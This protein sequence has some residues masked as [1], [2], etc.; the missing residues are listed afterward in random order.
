MLVSNS[1]YLFLTIPVCFLIVLTDIVSN[2]AGFFKNSLS[3]F[4]NSPGFY[5]LQYVLYNIWQDAGIRTRVAANAARRTSNELH[6]SLKWLHTS[7]F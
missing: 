5:I 3:L 1:L 7:L 6:T 4:A 2:S